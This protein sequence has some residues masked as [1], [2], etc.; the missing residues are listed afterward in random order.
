VVGNSGSGIG[1]LGQ[2]EAGVAVYGNSGTEVGVYGE[3]R[4]KY[5]VYGH[6]LGPRQTGK[7]DGAGV[8]GESQHFDGVFGISHA[9]PNDPGGAGAGVSGHNDAGGF[10]G[11]F[12]GNV[13][14]TGALTAQNVEGSVTV[15]GTVTAHDVVLSN[16][17]CAEDFDV[18]GQ[19]EIGP[20]TV[21]VIDQEGAL[22]QGSEAYDKKVA[23]V[24]SGGGDFKPGIV[25]GKQTSQARRMPIAL[26]GRVYCKVDASY[27]P[28]EVGDLLTTSPTAGHAMKVTD[29][30]MA[31]GSVIGKALRGLEKGQGLIPILVALQ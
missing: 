6:G 23:G 28:I 20:G 31:I 8:F 18:A 27:S 12:E 17:D 24:V 14:V 13:T 30:L 21:M 16:S 5:G 10:A 4:T 15:T 29:P 3:S 25:L 1:V 26:V 7:A 2:C 22:R 11:F 9:G 19:P